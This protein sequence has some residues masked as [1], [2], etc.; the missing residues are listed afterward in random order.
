MHDPDGNEHGTGAPSM[1]AADSAGRVR[2]WEPA[3]AEGRAPGGGSEATDGD[4]APDRLQT[5]AWFNCFCGVA[6]DMA[7]GALLDAGADPDAVRDILA[8]LEVPGWELVVSK[9][10]RGGITAT[11]VRVEV[12]ESGV[13]RTAAHILGLIAEADLPERVRRRALATFGALATVEARLHGRPVEQVHFHE[14]GGL[15]AI[16]DI[17]GTCAALEVLDVGEVHVGPIAQGQGM[18]RSAHGHLP[19]PAPA[20][21]EL[22]RGAPTFGTDV[23]LELTTPTGAALMAALAT[24]FGT[25]P[26]MT[27]AAV[28]YGA[29]DRELPDRPN[30]TQVVVGRGAAALSAGQEV[31]LLETNVDDVTG[32]TLAYTVEL[33]LQAGAHDAWITPVVMKKGRPAHTVSVLTDPAL[34]GKLADVLLAETG[35]LGVRATTMQRWPRARTVAEVHVDGLPVR[36]KVAPNRVK[37]EHGDAAAVAAETGRPLREVVELATAAWR[38]RFGSSEPHDG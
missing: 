5:V 31:Q 7:L 25:M 6:G 37:V 20:T 12:A 30:V 13:V 26:A 34:A 36:L 2:P 35:S 15:D 10:L 17:V 33:L 8:G 22:L 3:I 27:V 16:V 14:V 24:R 19:I 38:R 23:P 4:A 1:S 18:I 11:D 32:E 21:V 9:T 29:G 28:G